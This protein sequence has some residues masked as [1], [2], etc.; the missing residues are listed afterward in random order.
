MTKISV[1][2]VSWN[3]AKTIGATIASVAAQTVP[4][5]HIVIDGGSTDGTPGL[6]SAAENV[7]AWVS[8]RDGGLYDAMNKGIRMATGDYVGFLNA[9][10][11]LVGTDAA[12]HVEA[13]AASDADM[14]MGDIVLTGGDGRIVRSYRAGSFRPWQLR[15]GHMPPHPGLY[16]RRRLLLETPFRIDMKIGA[17]FDQIVRLVLSKNASRHAIGRTITDMRIGGVS[18][19][20]FG[21]TR[22]I[23]RDFARVL[24]DNGVASHPALLWARYPVKALQY[25][26]RPADLPRDWR[27]PLGQI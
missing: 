7:S 14:L 5:E 2:T 16:V 10:D 22:Q 15:F 12:A 11:A 25:L 4:T 27:S 18:T 9:D 23:N 8:E 20:G 6:L 24:R 19:S 26:G 13:A 1:I 21:A 17:D 3:A